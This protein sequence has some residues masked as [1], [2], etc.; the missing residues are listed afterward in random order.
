[1][2]RQFFLLGTDKYGRDL[3]S[4]LLYGARVSLLIGLLA[5]GLSLTL[6]IAV[7]GVAAL[8]GGWIDGL[9]MRLVDGLLM[10]PR[11]FSS[12]WSSRRCSIS[13]CWRSILVLGGTSWMAASR[14]V[15]AEIL[16]LRGRDFVVAA[17]GI[18]LHPVRIF[19]RHLLPNALPPVLIDTTQRIGD[20]IL[21]RG[22]SLLPGIR[23]TAADSQLGQHGGRRRLE[24]DHGVGGVAAFP[25][26]AICL[27]VVA[28]N[29]LGDGLR[30]QP[31]SSPRRDF[32]IC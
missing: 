8:A 26:I 10:F 24:P 20:L 15:R 22:S 11:P 5:A 2:S 18:G 31:R 17:R 30:E 25:G 6:G 12:C 1:M 21:N 29:L 4:R 32:A 19:W 27:A 14:L 23:S 7:G 16:C 9:L 13:T 28:F 3:W